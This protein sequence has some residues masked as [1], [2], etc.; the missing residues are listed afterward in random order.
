MEDA[1]STIVIIV[2][3][4][5]IL[6]V[7]AL[8]LRTTIRRRQLRER[9]GPEYECTVAACCGPSTARSR[10]GCRLRSTMPATFS[11][12]PSSNEAGQ[13]K[14]CTVTRRAVTVLEGLCCAAP[15]RARGRTVAPAPG[16]APEPFGSVPGISPRRLRSLAVCCVVRGKS[17]AGASGPLV[18]AVAPSRRSPRTD[19]NGAQGASRQ[20]R[21]LP[22]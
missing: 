15:P 5:V 7:V 14:P 10:A 17:D 9:F 1:M 11:A 19:E 3:V 2:A 12:K 18:Y 8:V 20:A 13:E 4:V 22:Q 16:A 21:D 6:A